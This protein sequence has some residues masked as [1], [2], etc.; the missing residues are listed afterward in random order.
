[1]NTIRDGLRTKGTRAWETNMTDSGTM[2]ATSTTSQPLGANA[3]RYIMTPKNGITKAYIHLKL[4]KILGISLKKLESSFSFA[5]VPHCI[6]MLNMWARSARFKWNDRPPKKTANKKA[7]LKFSSNACHKPFSPSRYRRM[8]RQT[9][10]MPVKT[11][12]RL[13]KTA[14]NQQCQ[15][16]IA[17]FA[18]SQF[19]IPFQDC[20]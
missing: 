9:L 13:R 14:D 19:D 16:R 6:L 1:L 11:T 2:A 20:M 7:H 12:R 18:T 17:E 15:K 5:V 10:P 4:L 3:P 8:A